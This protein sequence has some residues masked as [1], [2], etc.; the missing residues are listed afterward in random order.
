MRQV[1][2]AVKES[3]SLLIFA[4][5]HHTRAQSSGTSGR[6]ATLTLGVDMG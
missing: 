2:D 5:E 1:L 4:A 3:K 6:D